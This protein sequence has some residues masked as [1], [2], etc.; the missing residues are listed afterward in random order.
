MSRLSFA[1]ALP[2]NGNIFGM[3]PNTRIWSLQR[4][5]I[6]KLH[7]H[8]SGGSAGHESAEKAT[9]TVEQLGIFRCHHWTNQ[10]S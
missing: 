10:K 1:S 2:R 3:P 9:Q 6:L 8:L 5:L 7:S 4:S